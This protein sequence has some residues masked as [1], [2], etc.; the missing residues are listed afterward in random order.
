[1]GTFVAGNT[2]DIGDTKPVI[3]PSPGTIPFQMPRISV[4]T[5]ENTKGELSFDLWKYEVKRLLMDKT[6][7]PDIISSAI[8]KS[9][10]GEAGK[11]AMRLGP[12]ASNADLME[13]LENV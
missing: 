4:F 6:Y 2:T 11:V 9:L 13:K 10:R 3:A 7:S 1:M 12:T 5:G 8:K